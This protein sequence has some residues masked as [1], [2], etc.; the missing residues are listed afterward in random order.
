MDFSLRLDPGA[1]VNLD[2]VRGNA[3]GVQV[4]DSDLIVN[5]GSEFNAQISRA[6]IDTVRPMDDPRP[7][8][9]F[10][11]G[12]SA[13]AEKLGRDTV[14]IITSYDGLVEVD[15]NQEVQGEGRPVAVRT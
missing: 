8:V 14:C 10:P 1:L 15:F 7:G 13:A 6:A 3:S 2:D 11:M 4:T 5:L 12:L 9:Y